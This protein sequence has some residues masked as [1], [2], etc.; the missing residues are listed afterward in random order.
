MREARVRRG[1]GVVGP[2]V[3]EAL[4]RPGLPHDL[5][6]LT[7]EL[8][9]LLLLPRVGAGVKLRALV[10]PDA[11]TEADVHSSP[12]QIVENGEILGQPDGM[13]PHGDVGHLPDPD[14][15]GPS[16]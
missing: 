15:A 14:P 3:S 11:A 6:G 16:R 7:E 1:E 5:D 9:I 13:P 10:R 8:A 2:L 4:F 12:G